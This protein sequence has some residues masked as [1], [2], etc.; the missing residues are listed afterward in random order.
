MS[1]AQTRTILDAYLRGHDTSALAPNAVF[2]LMGSGQRY[3]GHEAIE[4]LLE[5]FY[6]T[7][8]D[9]DFESTRLL[10]TEDGAAL[11]G[12][13]VGIHTGEFMGIAA[14]GKQVR[15]PMCIVYAVGM[16]GIESAHI[17]FEQESLQAQLAQ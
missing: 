16:A 15:V 7:A 17:Y 8:F 2:T 14:T 5:Y 10:V 3:E 12:H 13:L 4:G 1:A 6:H 11:E 9:A